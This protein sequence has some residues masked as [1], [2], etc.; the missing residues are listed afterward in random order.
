MAHRGGWWIAALA[1]VCYAL[2]WVGFAAHWEWLKTIDSAMLD[3][4]HSCGVKHPAWVRFWDALCTVF[5]PEAF[6]LVGIGVIV[7]AV[8]RRNVR[9]VLLVLT[10]IEL[11]GLVTLIAKGLA[12]RSRPPGALVTPALSSFP[13]GHA[14]AVAAAVPALLT[15]SAGL[16]T[17]RG[18]TVA[19]VLGAG[20]VIAVGVGRVVLNVHYPSDVLAGWALGYVW[21]VLC[22]LVIRP[23]PIGRAA[24]KTPEAPDTD[25]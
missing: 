17:R 4:L 6:R 8:L 25:R 21:Y 12:N 23:E 19:I 10:T 7:V 3:P 16:F 22:L 1:A 20:V 2:L 14:L 13:S 5:G 24:D 18:R 11:A 9:V 15:I